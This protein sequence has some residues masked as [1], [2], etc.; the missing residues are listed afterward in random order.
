MRAN[1]ARSGETTINHET[2]ID[3]QLQPN[4][5]T[6]NFRSFDTSDP[7]HQEGHVKIAS[8]NTGSQEPVNEAVMVNQRKQNVS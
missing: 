4:T 6:L 3:S 5:K 7:A 2:P 1:K 8:L